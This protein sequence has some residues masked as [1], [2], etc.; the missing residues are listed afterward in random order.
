M[1]RRYRVIVHESR[2]YRAVAVVVADNPTQARDMAWEL[3]DYDKVSW[4]SAYDNR[5]EREQDVVE[6]LGLDVAYKEGDIDYAG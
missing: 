2:A 1:K 5:S 6:D 4:E 3:A